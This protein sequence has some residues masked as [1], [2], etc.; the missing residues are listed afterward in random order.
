MKMSKIFKGDKTLW[1]VFLL[2]SIISLVAVYSSIG[3]YAYTLESGGGPTGLFLRHLLIVLASW[4]I[5]IACSR[6]NYR[7]F[8]RFAVLGLWA[9]VVLLAVTLMMGGRWLKIP[10]VS[11]FQPSEVAKIALVL[12]IARMLALKKDQVGEK[13]MFF[14]LLAYVVLVVFFVLP[15]NF[16]TAALLFISCYLMLFFGGVDRKWWWRILIVLVLGASVGL[17]MTYHRYEQKTQT[18]AIAAQAENNQQLFE[19]S[20]TWGHRVYAW[21]NPDTNLTQENMA[22]MAI[23]RGGIFGAGVGQTI[24][25]RLMTQS[26]N[27]FIYA[28]IIEETGL[29]GGV[30]VLILYSF[31]YFR[32]VRLAWRC[33]GRFGA[34]TVAGLST[35][36]YLQA[37]ANMGVAAG[38]LP[39]TGQTLPF[40][41]YGGT[42]Y[43]F[44]GVGLGIIQSVAADVYNEESPEAQEVQEAQTVQETQEAFVPNE[45]IMTITDDTDKDKNY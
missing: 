43:L 31:F 24:H 26:H 30:I 19:R 5:V 44:L 33:N 40:I 36:I 27:D 9:S 25:A 45:E 23:A 3:L 12:F 10:V 2:L 17:Y 15:E 38:V 16:S 37:L 32:C 4:V 20:S 39:V 8:S 35:M 22:R 1:V 42:A 21:L 13:N 6:V 29:V 41:S 18:T 28:I 11:Q 14:S 34:L 7:F